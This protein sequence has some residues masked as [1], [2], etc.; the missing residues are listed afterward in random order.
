M[1]EATY[2]PIATATTPQR[3]WEYMM[4]MINHISAIA[5][6]K[7]R[8]WSYQTANLA[9]ASSMHLQLIIFFI[10]DLYGYLNTRHFA[11]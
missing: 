7:E 9:V 6:K 4:I 2:I 1:G 11:Q 5:G 10:K 3:E 8:T